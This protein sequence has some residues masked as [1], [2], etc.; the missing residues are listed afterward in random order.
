MRLPLRWIALLR[1]PVRLSLA[2]TSGI[3]WAH[4]VIKML[5]VGADATMLCSTLLRHGV[6]TIGEIEAGLAEWLEA[7]EYESVWQMQ[8]S[9]SQVSCPD[10]A[11]F[12]RAQYIKTL[13]SYRFPGVLVDRRKKP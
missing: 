2:A 3:H 5:L 9:M 12:E 1:G 7:H 8:G 6:E 11:E 13:H 10:P 4:D